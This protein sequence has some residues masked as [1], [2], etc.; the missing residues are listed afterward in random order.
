MVFP[1]ICVEEFELF[2]DTATQILIG[3]LHASFANNY[4]F[5]V[6]F[7][8]VQFV[9]DGQHEWRKIVDITCASLMM[10]AITPETSLVLVCID[11]L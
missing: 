8:Q 7:I 9:T 1:S 6:G 10:G 5:I 3:L 11:M 2:Q 4:F